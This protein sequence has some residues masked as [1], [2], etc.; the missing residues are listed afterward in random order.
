[1]HK[2]IPC[3]FCYGAQRECYAC[4]GSGREY[5]AIKDYDEIVGPADIA[6]LVLVVA[7]ALVISCLWLPVIFT[8][9]GP[10]W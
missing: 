6:C 2:S 3:R 5:I 8:A 7:C 4:D 1:M 10:H 9:L